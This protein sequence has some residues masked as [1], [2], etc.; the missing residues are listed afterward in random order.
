[1]N[2]KF[3]KAFTL[4]E[5]LIV[6]AIIGILA[7]IAVPNFLNAQTRAEIARAESD[8]RAM[9]VALNSYLVDRGAYPGDHDQDDL[10]QRGFWK[11]TTPI[12]YIAV[13]PDDPF[14]KRKTTIGYGEE[15]APGAITTFEGASGSDNAAQFRVHA[16][17]VMSNG[18][19]LFDDNSSHDGFPF[20][21]D[22]NRYNSSNGLKSAGNL[23]RFEGNWQAGCFYYDV[24]PKSQ[25]PQGQRPEKRVGSRC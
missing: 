2:G 16:Y 17:S 15:Y 13:L 6:V 1:M 23:W 24:F 14:I 22:V 11:L 18:P 7:A 21:T 9:G 12:A 25:K 19:N 20:G 3:Q 10:S 8:M 5:L 4:I